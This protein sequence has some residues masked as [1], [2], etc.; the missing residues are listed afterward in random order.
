MGKAAPARKVELDG[1]DVDLRRSPVAAVGAEIGHMADAGGGKIEE[2]RDL[3]SELD[4]H[5]GRDEVDAVDAI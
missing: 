5:D 1:P 3:T 2:I 4:T